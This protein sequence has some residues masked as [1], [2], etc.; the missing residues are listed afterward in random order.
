M[1]LHNAEVTEGDAA[2][3]VDVE[4]LAAGYDSAN[5]GRDADLEVEIEVVQLI[6]EACR[7]A[8]TRRRLEPEAAGELEFAARHHPR[9][10][11]TYGAR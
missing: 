4:A 7:V 2:A 8:V 5:R 6:D 11:L 1:P 9:V 10:G 3:T